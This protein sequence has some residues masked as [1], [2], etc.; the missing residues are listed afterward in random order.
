MYSFV[1]KLKMKDVIRK[2]LFFLTKHTTDIESVVNHLFA[3]KVLTQCI[4]E[5]ILS[6][7]T[8]SGKN[9]ELYSY[10]MRRNYQYDKLLEA[11]DATNNSHIADVLCPNRKKPVEDVDVVLQPSGMFSE[12]I[13]AVQAMAPIATTT[14][15]SNL[16]VYKT[17]INVYTGSLPI[18]TV[19]LN[20]LP[21][22]MALMSGMYSQ[23]TVQSWEGCPTGFA[24]N[25][26]FERYKKEMESAEKLLECLS[27]SAIQIVSCPSEA[28]RP[29]M[30]FL[31]SST[32]IFHPHFDVKNM[33]ASEKMRIT[34]LLHLITYGDSLSIN[35]RRDF[36]PKPSSYLF[37]NPLAHSEV[38]RPVDKALVA[39]FC[40][41]DESN[42]E[43]AKRPT[44]PRP[45]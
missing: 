2:N 13:E 27:E 22:A 7:T 15:R 39:A 16:P 43:I 41:L 25:D 21:Y 33:I 42:T 19:G 34:M 6:K 11:L 9:S 18:S 40:G 35:V 5:E 29:A 38:I 4:K 23:A 45:F 28:M 14:E 12:L 44:V 8:T 20:D 24:L 10:M 36:S 30:K 26:A 31:E 1:T 17:T 37:F 3:N 32:L